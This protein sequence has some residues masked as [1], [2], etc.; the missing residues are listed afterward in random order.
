MVGTTG[1]VY[2]IKSP[3]PSPRRA[4]P[5]MATGRI[6]VNMTPSHPGDFI[7]TEV[8]EALDLSVSRTAE[9]LR[10][11]STAIASARYLAGMIDRLS[12]PGRSRT[13]GAGR[14]KRGFARACSAGGVARRLSAGGRRRRRRRRPAPVPGSDN[15]DSVPRPS[16][17]RRR[18]RH[19]G[20][21]PDSGAVSTGHPTSGSPEAGIT[22]AGTC[23]RGGE[24][25]R[26]L[27]RYACVRTGGKR[28]DRGK[29]RPIF[30]VRLPAAAALEY[31]VETR[32]IVERSGLIQSPGSVRLGFRLRPRSRRRPC[33]ARPPGP[34]DWRA[35]G[36]RRGCPGVTLRPPGRGRPGTRQG[37]PR[38]RR[39]R[40]LLDS[41]GRR[42]AARRRRECPKL[43]DP[44]A[45]PTQA[46][47]RVRKIA[48]PGPLRPP[49]RAAVARVWST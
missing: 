4:R 19:A 28:Q 20:F 33:S 13:V 29:G 31:A 8:V 49:G 42:P 45:A 3:S 40:R 32:R 7:R 14:G 39:P 5:L 34:C 9:I 11:R 48:R 22:R 25:G 1:C 17:A 2:Y 18:A 23:S 35:R 26:F 15:G 44:R 38:G 41:P 47:I 10:V 46:V 27:H 16:P 37:P 36:P 43:R 30:T 24:T 6:K 12:R 21:R